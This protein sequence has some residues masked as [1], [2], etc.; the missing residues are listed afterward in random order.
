MNHQLTETPVKN[1]GGYN[2]N[3]PIR[4]TTKEDRPTKPLHKQRKRS[5]TTSANRNNQ[6]GK[7]NDSSNHQPFIPLFKS[8]AHRKRGSTSA[9]GNRTRRGKTPLLINLTNN[10]DNTSESKTRSPRE[11]NYK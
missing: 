6:L 9:K 1:T 11:K 3:H 7:N 8:T 4:I 10:Q 5:T 2:K